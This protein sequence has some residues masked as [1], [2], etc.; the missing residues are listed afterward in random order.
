MRQAA[1][2]YEAKLADKLVPWINNT[3][4]TS[5]VTVVLEQDDVQAHTPNR[6]QYFLQEQNFSFW[7]K[8]HVAAILARRHP[9]GLCL[10][11]A[12]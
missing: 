1:R 9:T 6:V 3:I 10:L 5:S 2:D 4:D 7:S 11:T 12:Y 8:K